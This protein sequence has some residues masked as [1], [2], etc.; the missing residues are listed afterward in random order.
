MLELFIN[1]KTG[2]QGIARGGGGGMGAPLSDYGKWGV[3]GRENLLTP[4]LSALKVPGALWGWEVKILVGNLVQC[5]T[6][7]I[8]VHSSQ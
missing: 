5:R 2:R 4:L 6:T 7:L 3:E 1:L 8:S